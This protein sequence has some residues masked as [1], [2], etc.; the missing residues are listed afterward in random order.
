MCENL[1]SVDGGGYNAEKR[2]ENFSLFSS[3]ILVRR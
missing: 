3:G 2:K 1:M